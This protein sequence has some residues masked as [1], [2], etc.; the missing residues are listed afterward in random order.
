M[1]NEVPCVVWKED[2]IDFFGTAV[3]VYLPNTLTRYELENFK[4]FERWMRTLAENLAF[5][6]HSHE[7][8]FHERPYSLRSIEV[9]SV[10]KFPNGRV[11]FV[12]IDAA[13]KQDSMPGDDRGGLPH[14][15]L[16]TV[17][18]RGG[19][20][21]ILIILRPRD[22]T[23][24]RY[25][26][27]AEQPRLPTGSLQFLEIPTG[28]IDAFDHFTGLAAKEIEEE[29]GFKFPMS[30]LINMTQ[31]ALG[32]S[33]HPVVG[34]SSAVYPSP[35]SSDEHVVLYL[36]EKELDRLEIEDLRDRFTG[37]RRKNEIMTLHVKEYETLWRAGARDAK[38]LAAAAL[39]EGLNRSGELGREKK[40]VRDRVRR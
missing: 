40:R 5:Q 38:T 23:D 36:W 4:A 37:K 10:T 12:K 1:P 21:A 35:G 30:E 31:L 13:V 15:L 39:Y 2:E 25:V 32:D 14:S 22:S 34:L 19:S 28:M 33:E 16:G 18:L 8:P 29:T 20:V 27:M 9:K 17:F 26:I 6:Y 7:H 11:G 24:D 3:P